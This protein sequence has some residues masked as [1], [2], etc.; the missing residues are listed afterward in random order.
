[1]RYL[2]QLNWAN[3]A[4]LFALG[5]GTA[6]ERYALVFRQALEAGRL[7]VLK[8]REQVSAAAVRRNKAEALGIVKPFYCA[9]LSSH[10][11]TS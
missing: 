10:V 3:V 8:V 5:A 11:I 2:R 4:R 9:S 7:N 1:M 6:L